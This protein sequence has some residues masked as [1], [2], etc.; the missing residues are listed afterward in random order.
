M[1]RGEEVPTLDP[2]E[3]DTGEDGGG[4]DDDEDGIYI[5]VS[6]FGDVQVNASVIVDPDESNAPPVEEQIAEAI[7]RASGGASCMYSVATWMALHHAY[8]R[9][10]QWHGGGDPDASPGS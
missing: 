5:S 1:N 7:I 2:P 4:G 9:Q 3:V 10:V 8:I 6:I